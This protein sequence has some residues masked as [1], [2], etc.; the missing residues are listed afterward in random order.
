MYAG[1]SGGGG[2]GIYLLEISLCTCRQTPGEEFTVAPGNGSI[3]ARE[4]GMNCARMRRRKAEYSHF[5]PASDT[6]LHR[7]HM[8]R[9]TAVG[10]GYLHRSHEPTLILKYL[11]YARCTH[12][13]IPTTE[14]KLRHGGHWTRCPCKSPPADLV[15]KPNEVCSVGCELQFFCRFALLLK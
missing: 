12:Q 9:S 11:W 13:I 6:T 14:Y 10:L 7:P 2:Q 4:K 8:N 5:I 15:R 3:L 1:F